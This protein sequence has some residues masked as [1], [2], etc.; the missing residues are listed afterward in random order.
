[1]RCTVEDLV[2][3]STGEVGESSHQTIDLPVVFAPK[4]NWEELR[5]LARGEAVQL[6]NREAIAI[7]SKVK[8]IVA[9]SIETG[10]INRL[11]PPGSVVVVDY[12]DT[13]LEDDRVYAIAV[14]KRTHARRYRRTGGPERFEPDSADPGHETIYI[15]P[16]QP[17]TVLGRI[18]MTTKDL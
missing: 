12:G 11:A 18:V 13:R 10:E 3:T 9:I 6:S 2:G 4:L 5:T 16:G 14:G 8:T 7:P 1:M 17:L 15:E